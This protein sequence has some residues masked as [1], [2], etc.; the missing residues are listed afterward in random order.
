MKDKESSLGSKLLGLFVEEQGDSPRESEPDEEP[1]ANEPVHTPPPAPRRQSQPVMPPQRAPAM[2]AEPAAPADFEA[3]YASICQG[4]EPSVDAILTAF[5][6]MS[7]TLADATLLTAMTSMIKGIRADV[8]VIK[9][10][11][12]RRYST[13]QNA[14]QQN[15]ATFAASKAT[16]ARTLDEKREQARARLQQLNAQIAALTEDLNQCELQTQQAD[17]ADLG[18]MEAFNQCVGTE[19]GRLSTLNQFLEQ[20]P[21]RRS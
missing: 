14:V 2:A 8:V 6:E 19:V 17:A 1:L 4:D 9:A 5:G 15:K 16:R 11:L 3:I 7:K 13:L 18:T 21:V 20:L 12:G 10:A